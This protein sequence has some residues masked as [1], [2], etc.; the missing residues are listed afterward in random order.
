MPERRLCFH[1]E[2]YYI[3]STSVLVPTSR[4]VEV[5]SL[6]SLNPLQWIRQVN[7]VILA[8][9]TEQLQDGSMCTFCRLRCDIDIR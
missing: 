7:L 5:A 4:A 6:D 9:G 1:I 2:T 8:I 3:R